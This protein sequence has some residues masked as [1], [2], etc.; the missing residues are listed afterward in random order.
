MTDQPLILKLISFLSGTIWFIINTLSYVAWFPVLIYLNLA[1]IFLAP[2]RI[3]PLIYWILIP[4]RWIIATITY[5]FIIVY[6]L[7]VPFLVFY[8]SKQE[9]YFISLFSSISTLFGW[10]FLLVRG[11]INT[12]GSSSLNMAFLF[13]KTFSSQLEM[14]SFLVS[15]LSSLLVVR[16]PFFIKKLNQTTNSDDVQLV[17]FQMFYRTCLDYITFPFTILSLLLLVRTKSILLVFFEYIKVLLTGSNEEY[18]KSTSSMINFHAYFFLEFLYSLFDLIVF[19]LTIPIILITIYRFKKFIIKFYNSIV[20]ER[21]KLCLEEILEILIDLPFIVLLVLTLPFF[22]R[23]YF[24]YENSKKY[25]MRKV[26]FIEFLNGL[27]DIPLIISIIIIYTTRYRWNDVLKKNNNNNDYYAWKF[28]QLFIFNSFYVLRDILVHLI[29]VPFIILTFWRL[30]QFYRLWMNVDYHKKCHIVLEIFV[31]I[32][33]DI[34]FILLGILSLHRLPFIIYYIYKN[35]DKT[36]KDYRNYSA[37]QFFKTLIDVPMV[38]CWIILLL[39]AYRF[40]NIKNDKI[41]SSCFTQFL[42]LLIDIPFIIF[43]VFSLWRIYLIINFNSNYK[44]DRLAQET[45]RESFKQFVNFLIDIPCILC[46]LAILLTLYRFKRL[47]QFLFN[48]KEKTFHLIVFKE[49]VELLIDIP[50]ILLFIFSLWRI[51]ITIFSGWNQNAEQRRSKSLEQ[52]ILALTDVPLIISL[53]LMTISIIFIFNIFELFKK[54]NFR[55][56]T[57]YF[58]MKIP[59]HLHIIILTYLQPLIFWRIPNLISLIKDS[60]DSEERSKI[61]MNQFILGIFDIITIVFIILNFITILN[62]NEMINILRNDSFFIKS[63]ELKKSLETHFKVILLFIEF[64]KQIPMGFSKKFLIFLINRIIDIPYLIGGIIIIISIYRIRYLFKKGTFRSNISKQIQELLLDLPL[65]LLSIVSC[66]LSPWKFFVLFKVLF[67]FKNDQK[68]RKE[69]IEMITWTFI[70][71]LCMIMLIFITLI[72]WRIPFLIYNIFYLKMQVREAIY[73]EFNNAISDIFIII[74]LSFL[75]YTLNLIP[76]TLLRI[77]R[78]FKHAF[79][80]ISFNFLRSKQTL[81]KTIPPLNGRVFYKL[82][83]KEEDQVEIPSE[84]FHEIF[85]YLKG[86]QIAKTIEPTCK[87]WNQITK[88]KPMWEQVYN[89]S[90]K[91]KVQEKSNISKIFDQAFPTNYYK[92]LFIKEYPK[93]VKQK[94]KEEQEYELGLRKILLE[95]IHISFIKSY[96]FLFIPLKLLGVFLI[97]LYIYNVFRSYTSSDI[98]DPRLKY[99]NEEA[100]SNLRGWHLHYFAVYTILAF[101]RW[102][103]YDLL[104]AASSFYMVL[105]TILFFGF[106]IW[107]P[108]FYDYFLKN[109]FQTIISNSIHGFLV[110][111]QLIISIPLLISHITLIIIPFFYPIRSVIIRDLSFPFYFIDIPMIHISDFHYLLKPY[112][113]VLKMYIYLYYIVIYLFEKLFGLEFVSKSLFYIIWLYYFLGYLKP[114]YSRLKIFFPEFKPHYYYYNILFTTF[115]AITKLFESIYKFFVFF[116]SAITNFYGN[117]LS[118]FTRLS[119]SLGIIGDLLL[120]PISLTWMFWPLITV[121]YLRNE[122]TKWYWIP[123]ILISILFLFRGRKIIANTK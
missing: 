59:F 68:R 19:I 94:S 63:I 47:I 56:E 11:N 108:S 28:H 4:I 22:W 93:K 36:D 3:E 115:E 119:K 14:L 44:G 64:I 86:D 21:A 66:L 71:F 87:E 17:C 81:N 48:E 62:I 102:I 43:G 65:I 1:Q 89:Y 27:L 53:F 107:R 24:V 103:I 39:T 25:E 8:F 55:K 33:I 78:Y 34:P 99:L 52:F 20:E 90:K 30:F 7:S 40:K 117:I 96:Q 120:I 85:T 101:I 73:K 45:R 74:G 100:E 79:K 104:S 123:S 92:N 114:L 54:N 32:L 83:P 50:F 97:P 122:I 112:I 72:F 42:E 95:Q 26:I 113:S 9:G 84:I 80:L 106:P 109:Q 51:P 82:F 12:K 15:L 35:Q 60:K 105:L 41:H 88:E 31:E 13:N 16:I 75:V 23:Y 91:I 10:I 2:K 38:I 118:F 69:M 58:G 49:F 67:L 6:S 57:I 121:Y 61:I 5:P 77:Y 46:F 116:F 111:Y 29:F 18:Y 76:K 110:V 37:E 98:K 70:D